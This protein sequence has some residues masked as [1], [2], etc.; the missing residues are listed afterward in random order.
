MAKRP[1]RVLYATAEPSSKHRSKPFNNDREALSWAKEFVRECGPGSNAYVY[2]KVLEEDPKAD[3][4]PAQ[5]RVAWINGALSTM[6][7]PEMS[8][9]QHESWTHQMIN[10]AFGEESYAG[11]KWVPEHLDKLHGP[12]PGPRR[13]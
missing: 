9:A 6:T 5:Y 4:V 13:I 7:W 8:R 11:P 2:P 1:W 3:P 10:A 12:L